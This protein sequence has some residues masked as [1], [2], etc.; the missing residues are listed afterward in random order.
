MKY[1]YFI[2]QHIKSANTLNGPVDRSTFKDKK[3]CYVMPLFGDKPYN[4]AR[5]SE[6]PIVRG[7]GSPRARWS[8]GPMVRGPDSPR[9]RWSKGPMVRGF[10]E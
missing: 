6:G 9:A 10:M 7:P 2:L 1:I 3:M 5:Y 8:E 4:V